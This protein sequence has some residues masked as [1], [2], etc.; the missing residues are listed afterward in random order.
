MPRRFSTSTSSPALRTRL[1]FEDESLHK[2]CQET[3]EVFATPG[4]PGG[5]GISFRNMGGP[6]V[7]ERCQLRPRTADHVVALE[8]GDPPAQHGVVDTA[9]DEA[10]VAG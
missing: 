4:A 3:A 1:A 8:Y 2:L 6:P 10:E 7:T 5:F 9:A